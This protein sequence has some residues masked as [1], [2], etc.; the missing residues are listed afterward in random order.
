MSM[1]EM[2]DEIRGLAD[3]MVASQEEVPDPSFPY[4]SLVKLFR[5][6]GNKTELLLKHGVRAYVRSYQD[7][8][9]NAITGMKRVTLSA[10]RLASFPSATW[11]KSAL[12]L[13]D[14]IASRIACAFWYGISNG[15]T[16]YASGSEFNAGE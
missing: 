5:R 4:D 13:P 7:Y 16:S 11:S 3:Y 1:F 10:L 12:S 6:Y 2:A 9:C 15:K 8:V 14:A